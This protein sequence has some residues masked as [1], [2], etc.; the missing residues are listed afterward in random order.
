[1]DRQP[2]TSVDDVHQAMADGREGAS[3]LLL[4]S[5]NGANRYVALARS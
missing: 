1:V 4:L 2:V 3:H 5:R